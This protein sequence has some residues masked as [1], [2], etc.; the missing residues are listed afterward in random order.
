MLWIAVIS[1][2]LSQAAATDSNIVRADPDVPDEMH[3]SKN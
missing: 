2:F 3:P 1:S